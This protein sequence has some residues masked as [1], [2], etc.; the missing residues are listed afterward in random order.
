MPLEVRWKGG[1]GRVLAAP[2][3]LRSATP[4]EVTAARLRR[5]LAGDAATTAATS[6][7][8]S[9]IQWNPESGRVCFP[10]EGD[11]RWVRLST[12]TEKGGAV[13]VE[14]GEPRQIERSAAGLCLDA[15]ST[16]AGRIVRIAEDLESEAWSGAFNSAN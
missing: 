14:T 2:R 7:A 11:K 10:G 8:A 16:S 6:P 9:G 3:W 5:L 13:Q 12:A 4:P 15:P 1:D